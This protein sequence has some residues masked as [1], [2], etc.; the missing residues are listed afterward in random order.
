MSAPKIPFTSLYQIHEPLRRE[1]H[2]H[3]D[4]L[5]DQSDFILG[6]AV[7]AFERSYAAYSSTRYCLGTS[8]GLD[9][10]RISLRALG[11]GSGDEVIVPANTY[12]ASLFAITD[13]GAVPVPA[14]PDEQTYNITTETI[15]PLLTSRT[16]AIMPVHLY[17]QPCE[18]QSIISLA[19]RHNLHVVEDNAQAQG[20]SYYGKKTGSFGDIGA[21]SFYPSKNL[22]AM[23]DAGAVTTD[24]EVLYRSA[25]LLHNMGSEKKY[26]HD[27]QG[28][29][30]RLD[31]IQAAILSSKLAYLDTWNNERRRIAERYMHNL[32]GL[33]YVA[34]PQTA[35]GAHH[36]FHLFVIR[37]K[38]RDELQS[39]L[40][41]HGI[42][43]LIHYPV[44]PH[45]QPALAV[46]GWQRGQ[47]PIT[48][49]IA[50]SCLSLPLFVGM[51]D[52]QIDFVS[53]KIVAFEQQ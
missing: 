31:T 52:D 6:S 41:A 9:A 12:I 40:A 10:L 14:E 13:I 22:G 29:N 26:F 16:K 35:E 33:R 44:S 8:N 28:Y 45:L 50:A 7:G 20:A 27:L 43:T 5:I 42:Q 11:I 1:M 37:L 49:R 19:R 48:E 32:K 23:G 47:F 17:G 3:L 46:Y 39:Y 36:V 53:E 30:A 21:T 2:E 25:A 38:R 51:T 24:N 18:M 34:L 15:A 4:R